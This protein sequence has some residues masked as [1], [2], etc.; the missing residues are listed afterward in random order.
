MALAD[1]GQEIET[2]ELRILQPDIENDERGTPVGERRQRRI[3]V[4]REP[5]LI[6]FILENPRNELPDVGFVIDDENIGCHNTT[7][8]IPARFL[9][10]EVEPAGNALCRDRD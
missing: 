5:R 1:D 9:V 7:L 10:A 3:A 2:V 8:F 4:A 6:A